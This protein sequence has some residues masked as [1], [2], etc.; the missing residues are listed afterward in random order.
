[1]LSAILGALNMKSKLKC[2]RSKSSHSFERI[3][4]SMGFDSLWHKAQQRQ[5]RE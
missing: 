5:E 1:M 4:G 2:L 3:A